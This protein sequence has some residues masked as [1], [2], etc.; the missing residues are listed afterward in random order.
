MDYPDDADGEALRLLAANGSDMARPM[1]VDFQ[2]AAPDK[3]CADAIARTAETVGYRA[4]VSKDH[5]ASTWTVTG[6]REMVA[7]YEALIR[8]QAELD[9]LSRP[10]GGSSDGWGTWGNGPPPPPKQTS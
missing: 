3:A 10:L 8:V 6:S 9:A 5:H 7:S 1:D 2:V 4:D